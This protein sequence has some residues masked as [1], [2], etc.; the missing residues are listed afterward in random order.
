MMKAEYTKI[1]P[2][3][4]ADYR[5]MISF[6]SEAVWPE[7]MLNS[8]VSYE[9][10]DG[11]F[12]KF[13]D[14]QFA[15][16]GKEYQAVAGIANSVPISW[17]GSVDELPDE[18]W[19]WAMIKSAADYDEE[20]QPNMLCGIQISIAPD[21]QGKGLS[22]ILL[23]EMVTLARLKGLPKVV[24]PV[25]PSLKHL[26]PLTP[27]DSYIKWMT[28]EELPYDPWLRVH[29]RN[30]GRIIKSCPLAMKI[31]GTIAQWESWTGMRFFD[32]GEYIVPGALV[33]V[34]IDIEGDLG[35][36]IEPNVW[37]VHEVDNT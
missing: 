17:Q 7:F 22:K 12:E 16:L 37:V 24:I 21:F 27:I 11:L 1:S 25:R 13:A 10:W 32:N 33:P 5:D 36:Y 2:K 9:Y 4:R 3:D 23:R 35:S 31:P 34:Q 6:V 18:G 8:P 14:Y 19:D 28:A 15:L 30:G 20:L 29:V 26:Y